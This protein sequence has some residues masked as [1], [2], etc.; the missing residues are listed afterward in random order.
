MTEKS[1]KLSNVN[2]NMAKDAANINGTV[3][4]VVIF[5]ENVASVP[6]MNLTPIFL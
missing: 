2:G 3:P 5:R 1:K 6:S 4:A